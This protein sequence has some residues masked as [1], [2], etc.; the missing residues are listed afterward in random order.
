MHF[1]ALLLWRVILLYLSVLHKYFNKS[2]KMEMEKT[3]YKSVDL[4]LWSENCPH[5][6][7]YTHTHV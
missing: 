2:D 1:N 5:E 4:G 3:R 7:I 6:H